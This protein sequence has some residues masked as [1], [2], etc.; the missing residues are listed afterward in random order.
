[1]MFL[2]GQEQRSEAHLVQGLAGWQPCLHA[3]ACCLCSHA[4]WAA[5]AVRQGLAG[6]ADGPMG[7]CTRLEVAFEKPF[8]GGETA[9]E[10]T[11]VE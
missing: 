3:Q 5:H 9:L 8:W 7:F 11:V 1:M 6:M 4:Q 2:T 10:Q